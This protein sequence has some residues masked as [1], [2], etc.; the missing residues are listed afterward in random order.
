MKKI[1]LTIFCLLLHWIFTQ[2]IQA[3]QSES[4]SNNKSS[5]TQFDLLETYLTK[6]KHKIELFQEKYNIYSNKDLDL[7]LIEIENLT[8]ISKNIKNKKIEWYN[9]KE[10]SSH[11]VKRIKI[12][13]SKLELILTQEKNIYQNN[14]KKKK[15]IYSKIWL[16]AGKQLI[17]IIEKLGNRVTKSNISI[18][19]KMKIII[20]L[21]NLQKNSKKLRDLT[22]NDFD[23]QWDLQE[24]FVSI[25]KEI[26]DDMSTI[27]KIL[28]K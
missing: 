3:F 14:L 25:L 10:I 19:I 6:H 16:K 2:N 13:N 20:H 1:V 4:N 8:L 11:I 23:N 21:K 26:R 28:K 15:E 5:Y 24:Y 22:N 12:I 27:K 17:I 9:S 7:L 18:E